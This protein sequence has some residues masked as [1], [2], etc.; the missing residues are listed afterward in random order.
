MSNKKIAKIEVLSALRGFPYFVLKSEITTGYSLYTQELREIKQNYL[1]YKKG[2]SFATEG[3]SGDY[4]PS[5]LRFKKI[6]T[7]IDRE[8]RFMFSQ[9]PDV[10]VRPYADDVDDEDVEKVKKQYQKAIDTALKNSHF[11]SGLLKAA[12]DCFIA[13]RVGCLVDY[14]EEDGAVVHFYNALQF[15][16]ECE[17]DSDRI[18]KFVTFKA[19][20]RTKSTG[21]RLFL[22]NKYEEVNGVVYMGCTLYN[23]FGKV[24][25]EVVAYGRTNLTKIPAVVILN[26]G[27]LEDVAG[28]SEVESMAD[29]ES[30]YSRLANADIDSERKG[31]NPIRYVVDMN[32]QTTK[33]L[34]SGAGAFWDLK[35][36]QNQNE[37]HPQV[38]NLSPQMNHTEPVKVTLDRIE[39]M[40]YSEIDM[41]N[42]SEDGA[43]SGITSFK[44]LKALYYPLTTRCNE[45]L[46]TWKPAISFIAK[47]IVDLCLLNRQS[48]VDIYKL[49][50]L[51]DMQYDIEVVENYAL[52]DDESEEKAS[53][54][55]EIT[56]NA[57]SR[58]SYIKKWRG[59]EFRSDAQIEAELMQIALELNMFDTMS[60]NTQVQ[61]Q[62]EKMGAEED[63]QNNLEEREVEQVLGGDGSGTEV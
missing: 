53:D 4:V 44:A 59:S 23:G 37:V 63:V 42:I 55:A 62:L 9:M 46:M 31:M 18:T 50:G 49:D 40:M 8:A 58:L 10:F 30:A 51:G 1:D 11:S 36:E 56:A 26:D 14:S 29:S 34:S 27:T 39:S 57:R 16:Y 22:V 47:C 25:D 48:A 61:G 6:K 54:I 35:S 32:S 5:S 45:K 12:K 2:A 13:G 60:I 20:N 28:V 38:G 41:P 19:V 43:L 17:Y 33:N 24:I 52:L 7:L 3:S 21:E 15:Y